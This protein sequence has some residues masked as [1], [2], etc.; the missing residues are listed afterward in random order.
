MKS[1]YKCKTVSFAFGNYT[2]KADDKGRLSKK[3]LSKN[4]IEDISN[5]LYK[6]F[7]LICGCILD[8]KYINCLIDTIFKILENS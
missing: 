1:I 2:M 6:E 3:C 8:E 4:E 7:N 5:N